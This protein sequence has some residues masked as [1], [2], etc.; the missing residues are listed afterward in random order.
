MPA[1]DLTANRVRELLDYDPVTGTLD[2]I[3]PTDK[4]PREGGK[5]GALARAGSKY[6]FRRFIQIDH[7]RYPAHRVIWLHVHGQWPSQYLLPRNGNYDDLRL[8]NFAEA[9]RSESAR[10]GG[11]SR[12]N[13][14]GYRGVTWDKVKNSWL[15]YITHNYKRIYIGNFKAKEDAIAARD[16][17]AANL[18]A[19]PILDKAERDAKAAALT[20]DA[21][22][23]VFWRRLQK[24]TGGVTNWASFDAFASDIQELPAAH[25][26]K[27][28]LR[29][30]RTE[31]TIGPD[32][33][34]WAIQQR[35][36]DYSSKDGKR[37][38]ARFHRDQHRNTYR[39]KDLRKNFG[40]SFADYQRMLDAQGGVCDIC[41]KP[42]TRTRYG[43]LTLLAV[44]HCHGSGAIRGLLC[45]NC[46]NGIGRFN[47]DPDLL[48]AAADYLE[49]HA[50]KSNGAASPQSSIEERDAHHDPST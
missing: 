20:R 33:F 45:N 17:A 19:L 8:E 49:R 29:P 16:A 18:G 47:D 12:A 2:W 24:Q 40:I 15:V 44:D 48:R 25:G 34:E 22:L 10:R 4:S 31:E 9:T 14:S 3:N 30:A 27:M 43:K 6:Q 21:R 7:H 46:N 28:F 37:A 41:K 13:T 23:R 32:N 1:K 36:W 11:P 50:I 42:E 26:R 38:Y 35:Q 5:A 39:D